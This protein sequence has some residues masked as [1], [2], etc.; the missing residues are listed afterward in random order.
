MYVLVHDSNNNA[1]ETRSCSDGFQRVRKD[2]NTLLSR[3]RVPSTKDSL[4][5]QEGISASGRGVA[6][7]IKRFDET[8]SIVRRPGSG[9]S[10]R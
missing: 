7:F 8:R 1:A 9:L 10:Y 6:L 5:H 3:P 4:L 2:K